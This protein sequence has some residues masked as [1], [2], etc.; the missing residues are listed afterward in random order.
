L[1]PWEKV[2]FYASE[3]E[4]L[5]KT[6][7]TPAVL[8]IPG[9]G[10]MSFLS[11]LVSNA[12]AEAF[13]N[14]AM[15]LVLHVMWRNHMMKFFILDMAVYVL[16]FSLWV[17]LIEPHGDRADNIIAGI[18]LVLNTLNMGRELWQ[19]DFCRNPDYFSSTW[20]LIDLTS[21]GLVYGYTIPAM[22]SGNISNLV[23]LA[24]VTT[25]LLTLV[26]VQIARRR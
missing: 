15:A 9:L 10:T 24:V 8:P 3:D 2:A 22:T 21:A 12:P 14:E 13:D 23:P 6:M 19:S 7:R 16:F 25:L 17:C 11:A 4:V 1:D 5:G 26:S 18:L 20:N